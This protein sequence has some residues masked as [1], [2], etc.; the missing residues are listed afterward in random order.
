MAAPVPPRIEANPSI[1][2]YPYGPPGNQLLL[3]NDRVNSEKATAKNTIV[4]ILDTDNIPGLTYDEKTGKIHF[5]PNTKKGT[6]TIK[7]SLTDAHDPTN[8]AESYAVIIIESKRKP[9]FLLPEKLLDTGT[10]IA[11]KWV[12]ILNNWLVAT[13]TMFPSLY[14]FADI[15]SAPESVDFWKARLR[16][17]LGERYKSEFDGNA[18]RY[19]VIP[20]IGIVTPVY[21]MSDT[22]VAT[23]DADIDTLVSGW[24][25]RVNPYL[26][27]GVLHYPRSATPGETGNMIVAGHSSYWKS[28]DGRYK[29]VFGNLMEMDTGEQVWVYERWDGGKYTRYVYRVTA[30]Y[31][32]DPK[33]VNVLLPDGDKKI[34]TLF[35]CTP[36]W[37][38]SG[39]W[40]IR[41]EM[42]K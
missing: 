35:T 3:P 30:S 1:E 21:G 10:P 5:P 16:E 24:E 9:T 27:D 31:N 36:V 2:K 15:G 29:T 14:G 41:G 8:R 33:D 19:I 11:K 25:I 26:K 38:L 18:A 17:T 4:K 40:I 6:Y 32:T 39:R 23:R 20:S 12:K 7:Y 22:D 37:G 13:K 34:I 28:D 42:V